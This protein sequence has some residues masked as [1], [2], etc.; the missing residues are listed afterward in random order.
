[1]GDNPSGS[2]IVSSSSLLLEESSSWRG[3]RRLVEEFGLTLLPARLAETMRGVDELTGGVNV[4]MA[5]AA[6]V[7]SMTRFR[8]VKGM[9][10]S[11]AAAASIT[12][13]VFAGDMLSRL[14]T[15]AVDGDKGGPIGA[16]CCCCCCFFFL[17][18]LSIGD[19]RMELPPLILLINGLMGDE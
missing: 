8:G 19:V 16:C 9:Q 17:A 3:R 14:F 6:A 18:E 15:F 13:E 2:V 11:S 1:M 12:N 10:S 4:K 5:P 7:A